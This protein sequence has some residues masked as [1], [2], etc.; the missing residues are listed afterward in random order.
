MGIQSFF[1]QRR[2]RQFDHKPIYW[3]ARR[4][5]LD[6]RIARIRAELIASGEIEDT[7]SSAEESK[8]AR[9]EEQDAAMKERIRIG[10][11]QG[12]EHLQK[13]YDRGITS[14]DRVQR[15]LRLILML[16]VLV[17]ISW[18]MYRGTFD[19]FI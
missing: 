10:L 11:R 13:Q 3:D 14:Y 8:V 6:K 4:E 15:I 7:Q 18:L 2:P 12:T 16:L 19:F 9:A 17:A 5:E 1:K